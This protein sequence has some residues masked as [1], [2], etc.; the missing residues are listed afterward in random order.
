MTPRFQGEGGVE[1]STND[2]PLKSSTRSGQG[3]KITI[4][5]NPH[6]VLNQICT[7]PYFLVHS[8]YEYPGNFDETGMIEFDYAFDFEVLISPEIIKTDADLK[9]VDPMKR[10]C[11]FQGEK[12]LKYFNYYTRR[13]CESEC[14][15]DALHKNVKINCTPYYMVRSDSMDF[16]DYRYEYDMKVQI[17]LITQKRRSFYDDCGCLDA[18]DSI[19]YSFEIIAHNRAKMNKSIEDVHAFTETSL[20]FRL[21]DADPPLR[22][23]LSFTF[24]EFLAQSG[25]MMGLFAGISVLSIIE[26][27]Y[28]LSMRWVMNIWRWIKDKRGRHAEARDK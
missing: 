3:L 27:I 1:V 10:G 25:G 19:N 26:L 6:F 12:Q 22:R 17:F 14:L 11:Y 7:S 18:C 23:Y 15:V 28:F 8:P 16:C 9:S 21:K 13:N 4:Q 2:Y 24:S 20:E 5:R